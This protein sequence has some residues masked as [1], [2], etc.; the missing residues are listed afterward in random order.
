LTR[1][2]GDDWAPDFSPDGTR[3]TFTQLPGTV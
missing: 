3:I 2:L 1:R